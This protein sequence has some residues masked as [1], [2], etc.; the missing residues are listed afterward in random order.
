MP[1]SFAVPRRTRWLAR[2]SFLF[3]V[4][5]LISFSPSSHAQANPERFYDPRTE[6][7]P[8]VSSVFDSGKKKK[9][10][11]RKSFRKFS[12]EKNLFQRLCNEV[13]GDGRRLLLYRIAKPR[14]KLGECSSC[15]DIFRVIVKTCRPPKV[16]K[17]KK[18][19][20]K[21]K[22]EDSENDVQESQEKEEKKTFAQREPS[23]PTIDILLH[24]FMTLRDEIVEKEEFYQGIRALLQALEDGNSD[25]HMTRGEREYLDIFGAYIRSVFTEA[26]LSGK[27]KKGPQSSDEPQWRGGDSEEE[28]E[29]ESL[30][31][32]S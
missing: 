2:H 7:P 6:E 10:K 1:N 20:K 15:K 32:T 14:E 18:K 13:A 24:V 4:L 3:L 23:A 9:E 30:F 11:K 22:E 8:V 31:G 29:L 27:P 26:E 12:Q 28:E 17:A 25:E 16:K 21:K 5:V 19:K